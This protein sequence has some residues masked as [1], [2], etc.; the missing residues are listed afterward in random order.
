MSSD[1]WVDNVPYSG[2]APYAPDDEVKRIVGEIEDFRDLQIAELSTAITNLENLVSEYTPSFDE[3]T[4]VIPTLDSPS[5]PDEPD[6]TFIPNENWP[7]NDITNPVIRPN[8]PDFSFVEPTAPGQIDPSFDYTPG[9]YTSCLWTELCDSIRDSL[10][11][12]GTGL[13]AS[14]HALIID[15]NQEARRNVEDASRQRAYDAVGENGFNL[16]GGQAAAVI[17][18]LEKDVLAKDIDAVNSTTI[19]DFDLADANSRFVKELASKME[20]I[21]LTEFDNEENRLFEIAK[22][23][24]EL[25]IATYEQNVK[26]YIA[27]W[28]GVKAKIESAKAQSE[29]IIAINDGEIKVFLGRI[30]AYKT[31]IEAIAAENESKADVVKA[32]A[33]VYDSQIRAVTAK[34]SALVEEIRS[35]VDVYRI[36]L[37]EVLEKEKI[38][39]DAYTS[40]ATLAERVAESLAN[41]AAQ[42]VAS[43]LGALNTTM[44][45]GYNGSETRG[46]NASISNTLQSGH[47]YEHEQQ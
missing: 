16:A 24:K 43:A 38:N 42:S 6:L 18:E 13:S 31:E 21:K 1:V 19:K 29:A 32:K 20:E 14:V 40:S 27:Q 9:T 17:M 30:E 34:F 47:S 23:T 37:T 5:F 8:A 7:E 41:I 35:A 22:V 36:Q 28:D 44:S 10:L 45:I 26:I 15:R 11:N 2:T 3:I 4:A 12:G 46:Y 33:S 25:V 39:L